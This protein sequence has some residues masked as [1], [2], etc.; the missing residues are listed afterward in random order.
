[1]SATI[2][3]AEVAEAVAEVAADAV[4]G[5]YLVRGIPT[6]GIPMLNAD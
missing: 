2:E 5:A 3:V 4:A 1:M 6:A